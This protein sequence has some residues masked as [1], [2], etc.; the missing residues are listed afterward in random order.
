MRLNIKQTVLGL[1]LVVGLGAAFYVW[2][3]AAEEKKS[4]TEPKTIEDEEQKKNSKKK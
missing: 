1:A 3:S 2:R 4:K